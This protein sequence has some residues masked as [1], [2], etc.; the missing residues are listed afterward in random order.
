M[1][2]STSRFRVSACCD[3]STADSPASAA[4]CPV[5]AEVEVV[6]P[7]VPSRNNNAATT[8]PTRKRIVRLLLVNIVEDS[9]SGIE[10]RD[11]LPDK[12]QQSMKY[13][14]AGS[15]RIIA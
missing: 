7:P 15:L 8:A 3:R 14:V 2:A 6:P 5:S 4:M 11:K 9:K 12:G 10:T 1:N 13:A